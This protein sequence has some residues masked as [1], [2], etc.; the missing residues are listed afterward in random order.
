[1]P[2]VWRNIGHRARCCM[3]KR[4]EMAS[5]RYIEQGTR[6]TNVD[7]GYVGREP[8]SGLELVVDPSRDEAGV[9]KRETH[10]VRNDYCRPVGQHRMDCYR[11]PS[12]IRKLVE[13]EWKEG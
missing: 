13:V 11:H 12:L 6:D 10:P 1:M 2:K 8:E 5:A 3:G 9:V 4:L 7:D